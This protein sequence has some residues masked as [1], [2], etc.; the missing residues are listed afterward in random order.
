MA[1]PC[2]LA[3]LLA[4]MT[5]G[6]AAARLTFTAMHAARFEHERAVARSAAEVALCDAERDIAG[7][8]APT[9]ARAA[10][11]SNA[12]AVW[13]Q[14]CGQG[15]VDR[16]LCGVQTPPAWQTLDLT[17]TNPAARV[18]VGAFTGATMATGAASLP[19][20]PPGYVIERLAPSGLYRITAIGF[21]PRATAPVVLQ[22]LYRRAQ[23]GVPPTGASPTGP[24][25]TG[26][27][28][29]DTPSSSAPTG[30]LA[31]REIADWTA[32]HA[33]AQP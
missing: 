6:L 24:L 22:A 11:F 12:A 19:A 4:T 20:R 1:L 25:S 27:P 16:G 5:I 13:P 14:N 21:G 28:S 8:A 18:S 33:Q 15:D 26:P 2:A 17:A 3:L 29:S 9:S 30:R 31:L 10:L 23:S 7:F 32:L